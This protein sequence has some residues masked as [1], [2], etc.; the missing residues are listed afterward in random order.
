MVEDSTPVVAFGEFSAAKVATLG[1]NPSR[2]E[3]QSTSG[4]LLTGDQRRLSTK[5]S[6]GVASL[7]DATDE[8]VAIVVDECKTYF[9]GKPYKQWFN[10]LDRVLNIA[11]GTSYYDGTAC[12]L[13]LV[14]WATDPVWGQIKSQ[15]T[16]EKLLAA[17]RVFLRAQLEHEHIEVVLANGIGVKNALSKAFGLEFKQRADAVAG[18]QTSGIFTA[19]AFGTKFVAWSKNIPSAWGVSKALKDAIALR[20]KDEIEPDLP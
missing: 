16:R 15:A 14:Q 19:H 4:E 12:H 3:F 8:Q 11:T 10:Q 1:L 9:Q 20:L 5:V 18:E 2:L 7:S 17:D 6:L 13:D